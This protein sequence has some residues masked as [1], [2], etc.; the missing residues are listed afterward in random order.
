MKFGPIVRHGA[1][2]DLQWDIPLRR[3]QL[4]FFAALVASAIAVFTPA[5]TLGHPTSVDT[6]SGHKAEDSVAHD[7]AAERG[8]VEECR[9]SWGGPDPRR[10]PS[11]SSAS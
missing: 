2:G 8:L 6:V 4:V 3:I 1:P 10:W 7:P 9:R 11:R 5:S